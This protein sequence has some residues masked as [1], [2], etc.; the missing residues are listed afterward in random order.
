MGLNLSKLNIKK[1]NIDLSSISSISNT[2]KLPGSSSLKKISTASDLSSIAKNVKPNEIKNI[3]D[4]DSTTKDITSGIPS[5]S[6]IL[7][8]KSS[9][10]FGNVSGM[11]DELESSTSN[12]LKKVQNFGGI[13]MDNLT[14]TDGMF[15]SMTGSMDNFINLPDADSLEPSESELDKMANSLNKFIKI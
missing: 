14:D 13:D 4:V 7:P 8:D 10:N 3:M 6:S 12:P 11:L 5:V 1:P 2:L 9:L 15:D